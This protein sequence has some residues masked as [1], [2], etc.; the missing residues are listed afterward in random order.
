MT[1][2]ALIT[3]GITDQ[4]VI[5]NI[6]FG[7]YRDEVDVR[8]LAP[9]RDAT[10]NARA[11]SYGGWEQ[12]L[13]HCAHTEKILEAVAINDYLIIQIDTDCGDHANFGVSIT[14]QGVDRAICDIVSDVKD[15]II[16]RLSV[17][18]SSHRHKFIFAISV[19]SLECWLL[20]LHGADK[21]TR[22]R[23]K[24]C[25]KHLKEKIAKSTALKSNRFKKDHRTYHLIS[26]KLAKSKHIEEVCADNESFSL[27]I[28][29]LPELFAQD[30]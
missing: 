6:L 17:A 7:Y 22:G 23:T 5:E 27:F 2:F 8:P 30:E 21:V 25:E 16:K 14:H 20:P 26:R 24:E 10:D 3:E 18:Y 15:L 28:A 11:G 13:E 1:S 9:S 29:Q 4:A 12:V 19:H